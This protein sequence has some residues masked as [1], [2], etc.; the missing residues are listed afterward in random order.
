MSL[1]AWFSSRS[2]LRAASRAARTSCRVC[3]RGAASAG[4]SSALL[5]GFVWALHARA[6]LRAWIQMG[7]GAAVG[8]APSV[9]H[10]LWVG[11][12]HFLESLYL[13]LDL[14]DGQSMSIANQWDTFEAGLRRTVSAW[15]FLG[16]AA[17]LAALKAPGPARLFGGLWLGF[18]VLGLA[19]GGWWRPHY[20]MQLTPP[21]A[22][23][24]A[25]GL[26][27]LRPTV[28]GFAWGAALAFGLMLFLQRDVALS[29][30]D[31]DAIS[32]ELFRRPGY[33]LGEEIADYVRG[34]TREGD[35]MY[36]AFAQAD[37]YYL[38]S[39]RGAAPQYYYLLAESSKKSFDS[40]IAAIEA[41]D[42][43]VVVWI[44]QPP[45]NRMSAADFQ[46]ILERGYA[47]DREF[48]IPQ[49]ENDPIVVF[50]RKPSDAIASS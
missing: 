31:P 22:F 39:R 11:S 41:R 30:R 25:M 28:N 6:G 36:V 46:A 14:Y 7:A 48:T 40:V 45:Q 17:S 32:W 33:I 44:Q 26:R 15:A 18:S 5:L 16:I 34:T 27:Q 38:A 47:R 21:L 23:L 19:A 29:Q 43:A 12:D 42:P 9:A 2:A 4:A 10:G 13:R 24:A 20:F 35:T 50:R 49:N 3:F 1:S 37:L 8:I